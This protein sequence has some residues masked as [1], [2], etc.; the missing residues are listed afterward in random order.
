MSARCLSHST[1]NV[2]S[3]SFSYSSRLHRSGRKGPYALPPSHPPPVSQ[4]S[5]QGR[6]RNSANICLVE[7]GS[8]STLKG[9]MSAASFLHSSFLQGINAVMLWPVHVEKVP[10][11]LRAPLPLLSQCIIEL[12][13]ITIL[14]IFAYM[15]SFHLIL[16]AV[17]IRLQRLTLNPHCL[18]SQSMHHRT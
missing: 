12:W 14:V 5:P 6:P 16:E 18:L 3:L 2:F 7:H 1:L 13:V 8:F 15:A 17:V 4:H 11:C 9:G 10:H